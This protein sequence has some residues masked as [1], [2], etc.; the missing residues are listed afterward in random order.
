MQQVLEAGSCSVTI[1]LG[2]YF[3]KW[4][5]LGYFLLTWSNS[6][7]R[8]SSI[9]CCLEPVATRILGTKCWNVSTCGME[10]FT[11]PPVL[12]TVLLCSAVSSVPQGENSQ[13]LPELWRG[14]P[15]TA[16]G[17][18]DLENLSLLELNLI[19]SSVFGPIST[20]TSRD[21]W[22]HQFMTFEGFGGMSHVPLWLCL[23]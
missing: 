9:S 14:N 2:S 6:M 15:P 3:R 11:N 8:V 17:R 18:R 1:W 12:C 16:Q 4:V 22:C 10:T 21:T 23:G 5:Y 20:S 13:L 7:D 19:N